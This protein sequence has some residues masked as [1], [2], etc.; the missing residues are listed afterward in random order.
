MYKKLL[1]YFLNRIFL[2]IAEVT[3]IIPKLNPNIIKHTSY[4]EQTDNHQLTVSMKDRLLK[5]PKYAINHQNTIKKIK[6]ASHYCCYHYSCMIIVI[7]IWC[8]RFRLISDQ[9]VSPKT[10]FH[11]EKVSMDAASHNNCISLWRLAL[12]HSWLNQSILINRQIW[13]FYTI[14]WLYKL[15]GRIKMIFSAYFGSFRRIS[16]IG[17]IL[18]FL[19]T[20][21]DNLPLYIL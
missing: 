4:L 14:L 11:S 17:C 3:Y 7:I 18:V 9:T 8:S 6:S 16:V 12:E 20:L 21:K 13:S 1:W 2:L 15:S 19:V 10:V 5:R